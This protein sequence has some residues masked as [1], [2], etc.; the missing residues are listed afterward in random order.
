MKPRTAIAQIA[1]MIGRELDSGVRLS[2]EAL[3]AGPILAEGGATA[4]IV[5]R[6]L[7]EAHRSHPDD[8]MIAAYAFLLEGALATLRLQAGGGDAE[9]SMRSRRFAT[10]SVMP[11]RRAVSRPRCLCCWRAPLHEP[12]LIQGGYCSRR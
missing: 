11:S 9:P 3:A 12:S 4:E 5:R 6:L 8:G 10:A 2:E 7:A 1:R